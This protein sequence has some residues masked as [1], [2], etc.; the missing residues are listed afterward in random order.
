ME[1]LKARCQIENHNKIFQNYIIMWLH[2]FSPLFRK[3]MTW[4][5]LSSVPKNKSYVV[6]RLNEFIVVCKCFELI[7]TVSARVTRFVSNGGSFSKMNLGGQHVTTLK[8]TIY[9]LL[10]LRNACRTVIFLLHPLEMCFFWSMTK[11]VHLLGR[12]D[13]YEPDPFKNQQQQHMR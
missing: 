12:Y 6:E 4:I 13:V 9:V 5:S 7:Q 11:L 2:S 1:T 3:I 10:S 8:G